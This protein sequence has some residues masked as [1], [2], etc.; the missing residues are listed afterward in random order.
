MNLPTG[1][2]GRTMKPLL[3]AWLGVFAAN[4]ILPLFFAWS[5]T[6]DAGRIG[7]LGAVLGL[8]ATGALAGLAR[9]RV[10]IALVVGGVPVALSQ[11]VGAPQIYAGSR[12][13]LV[14][15]AMGQMGKTR[16]GD[17]VGDMTSELGGFIAT[18]V[19]GG[20]LMGAALALA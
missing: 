4:L 15:E 5:I 17:P 10:G 13:L 1:G 19:T 20:I 7:M 9:C 8:L 12:G 18:V 16:P 11:L 3:L 14:A 2:E 6:R